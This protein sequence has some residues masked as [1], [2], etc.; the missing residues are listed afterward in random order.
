MLTPAVFE[1]RDYTCRPGRRD[2]L[3][4]MFERL[5][6]DSQ[7]AAGL[8]VAATFRDLDNEDRWVWIRCFD[9]MASRKAA[10]SA[11]YNSALWLKYRSACNATIT[12]SDNV[13]LLRP[14]DGSILREGRAPVG[15]TAI[16]RGVFTL[17]VYFPRDEVMFAAAF[18]EHA[19][20]TLGA[21]DAMPMA[22]FV[23]EHAE[24]NY[25]RLPIR[26]SE[27]VFVAITRFAS[28]AAHARAQQALATSRR[29]LASFCTQASEHRRLQP[30]PRS[31]LR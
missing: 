29:A 3:V 4:E 28:Q 2:D 24:N 16:P 6:L 15:A 11:F 1:L 20:P 25:K 21:A 12:D 10:L 22:T 30:T 27:T 8:R 18:R 19:L 17:D 31:S 26:N 5:F 7:E 9:N 13:L 14:R 23:T